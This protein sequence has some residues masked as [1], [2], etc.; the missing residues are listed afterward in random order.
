MLRG[1]LSWVLLFMG[2]YLKPRSSGVDF[3]GHG[4]AFKYLEGECFGVAMCV[5]GLWDPG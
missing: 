1:G 5:R 4:S 3:L 2:L